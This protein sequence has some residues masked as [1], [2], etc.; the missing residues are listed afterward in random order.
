M[1]AGQVWTGAENLAPAG[2]RSPDRAA[3]MES[4]SRLSYPGPQFYP[5]QTMKVESVD[6]NVLIHQI[7][8]GVNYADRHGTQSLSKVYWMYSI[9][10]FIQIGRKNVENG[11][12]IY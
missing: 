12:N 7:K 3:C 1:A 5:H 9:P 2:I 11:A 8:H 4:L 10:N 6:I